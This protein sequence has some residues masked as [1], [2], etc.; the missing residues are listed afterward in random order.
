MSDELLKDILTDIKVKLS[1]EFDQNFQRK[2]FFDQPWPQRMHAYPR[3]SLMVVTQRLRRSFRG[4]ISRN[5]VSWRSDAPYASLHNNG[6]KIPITPKMRSFFWAMYYKNAGKMTTLK[7]GK[8]SKSKRN[9]ALSTEAQFYKNMALTK[10][11]AFVVPQRRIIGDHPK[12][13][14]IVQDV[15]NRAIKEYVETKLLPILKK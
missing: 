15:A 14:T 11:D 4:S 13:K 12:V 3:G 2:A 9:V 6:G 1:D 5:S 7:S 10:K 8:A